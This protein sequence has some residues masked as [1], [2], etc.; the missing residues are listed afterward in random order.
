LRQE[1][2]LILKIAQE[3]PCDELPSLLGEIEQVR[4]TAI[5]R[6]S[7][8]SHEPSSDPDQLL[9]VEEAAKR[10]SMSKDYLYR[11]KDKYPFTRREGRKVLFSSSG[12]DRYIKQ[13]GDLTTK[14][15][16]ATLRSL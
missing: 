10:M 13:G 6:L 1:L 4:Y 8:P 5:A 2:Q 11:H 14:R 15:H 12:I 16:G 9:D 3:L 7:V